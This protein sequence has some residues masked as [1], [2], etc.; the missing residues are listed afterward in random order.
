M[1]VTSKCLQTRVLTDRNDANDLVR[2]IRETVQLLLDEDERQC[3]NTQREYIAAVATLTLKSMRRSLVLD[4][5]ISESEKKSS[6][7]YDLTHLLTAAAYTGKISILRTLLERGIDVNK[8]SEYFCYPL[9][10]AAYQGKNDIVQ[11]LLDHGS[12]INSETQPEY[13]ND[14]LITT[15]EFPGTPLQAASFGGHEDTVRLLLTPELKSRTSVLEYKKAII[16]AGHG[17]HS[18]LVKLLLEIGDITEPS[19]LHSLVLFEASMDGYDSVVRVILDSGAP[20]NQTDERDQT[21]LQYASLLGHKKVVRLL[22]ER[23]ADQTAGRSDKSPLHLAAAGGYRRVAEILLENG[24]EINGGWPIRLCWLTPF[25]AAASYGQDHML[26]FLLERG[27]SLP[28]TEIGQ[29]ALLRAIDSGYESTVGILAGYEVDVNEVYKE[30]KDWDETDTPMLKA[31]LT[32][33]DHIVRKLTEL[34]A[35]LIDPLK[36]RYAKRF[37]SGELP[38]RGF[39]DAPTGYTGGFCA[40]SR[41]D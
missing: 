13:R 21:C 31:I 38:W 28:G 17:G 26:P 35:Q 14:Y 4:R 24:A 29:R 6:Q 7:D 20:I 27:A 9:Q 10:A 34:G 36:T 8:R 41:C 39:L 37:L 33:H 23:G 2:T 18:S 11:L 3:D 25:A 5:L 15:S 16:Q 12:N 22:L 40:W 32:G 1:S 30:H 19:G